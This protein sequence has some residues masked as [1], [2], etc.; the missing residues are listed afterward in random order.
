MTALGGKVAIVTGAAQ[1]IGQVYAETLARDGAAVALVDLKEDKARTNAEAIVAAGGRAIAIGADV[2]DPD[3]VAA[4]CKQT[5]G[6]FGGIDILVNNAAIFE[7]YV[8]HP[9]ESIPLD[10]WNRFLDV[11]VTSVL[12][13]TQ[14][15]VPYMQE[16]GGGRIVNQSSDGAQ[17]VHSQYGLS[18]LLVQGL[19]VGFAATL[20]GDNITVNAIAPGPIDTKAMHDRHGDNV[21][22]LEAQLH[23][24]RLGTPADLAEVLAFIVSAKGEWITGQIFHINGGFWTRPA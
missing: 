17:S 13:C 7:G 1:G 5:A 24:K 11:N 21:A 16:R 9:L 6:E 2:S 3:A 8:A 14:A 12:A 22:N 4:F 23:I 10:Y 18:K 20:G 19:T 15:V